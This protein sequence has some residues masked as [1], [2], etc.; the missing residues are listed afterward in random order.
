LERGGT[1]VSVERLDAIAQCLKIPLKEIFNFDGSDE[2]MGEI[3]LITVNI[4]KPDGTAV[5]ED[6]GVEG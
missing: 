2:N 3:E 4:K 6:F 5:F 1:G